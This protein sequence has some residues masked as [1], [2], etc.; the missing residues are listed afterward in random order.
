MSRVHDS[1]VRKNN[2]QPFSQAPVIPR[3]MLIVDDDEVTCKQL[4]ELLE[5][6]PSLQ[7]TFQTDGQKA[8]DELTQRITAS[9]SP[10]CR[11][12]SWTACS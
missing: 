9:S 7:V 10:T 12:P 11:C 4:K 1:G 2:G 6:N 8:L 3:R 5:T